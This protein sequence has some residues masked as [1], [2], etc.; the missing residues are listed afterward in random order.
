MLEHFYQVLQPLQ[1]EFS[2]SNFTIF[3]ISLNLPTLSCQ[4]E[5]INQM[6]ANVIN[7]LNIKL[8]GFKLEKR[9]K[10]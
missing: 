5:A 2:Q 8:K 10:K 6:K 4:K 9:K 7:H 3:P 1:C